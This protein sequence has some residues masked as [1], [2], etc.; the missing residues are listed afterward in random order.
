M[1]FDTG[2]LNMLARNKPEFVSTDQ[3]AREMGAESALIRRMLRHL[4]AMGTIRKHPPDSY[5]ATPLIEALMKDEINGGL[6][7]W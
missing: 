3:L 6:H 4:A 5:A 2:I 7:F 1:A